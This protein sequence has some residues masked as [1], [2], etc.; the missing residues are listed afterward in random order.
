DFCNPN[1]C[2]NGATCYN[3]DNEN[4]YSCTCSPG[5]QGDDC[6]DPDF[7]SL[8]PCK[9]GATCYND[10]NENGYSCTCSPGWQGDDC[11]GRYI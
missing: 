1:P 5:W 2:K 4:G 3:D 7:C 10:D 8:N 9:N 6:G 11:G